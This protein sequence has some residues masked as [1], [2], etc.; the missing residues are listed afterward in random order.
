[1]VRAAILLRVQDVFIVS[2]FAQ[3]PWPVLTWLSHPPFCS[4]AAGEEQ[5]PIGLI[6]QDGFI[7]K[8]GLPCCTCGLKMPDMKDL[9]SGEGQCLC[10]LGRAQFPFGDKGKHRT[11]NSVVHSLRRN[12]HPCP[13]ESQPRKITTA[14]LPYPSWSL[15][16]CA[17]GKPV[18]AVCCLQCAPEVGCM[19]PGPGGG[20]AP[21]AVTDMER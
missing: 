2:C 8:V 11:R 1:M 10:C 16:S 18:C 5:F 14:R 19:K 12:T 21:P 9:I 20:G 4:C 7:C 15:L 17:V 13:R 3:L 6:S